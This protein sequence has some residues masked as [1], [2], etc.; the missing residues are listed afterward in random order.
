[1]S[2]PDGSQ[3]LRVVPDAG[4]FRLETKSGEA[5]GKVKVQGDRVKVEGA[6]GGARAKVKAKDY[7]FKVY[8]AGE[9]VVLKA[10]RRGSGFSFQRGDDTPLGRW[11]RGQGTLAG[12]KVEVV[13]RGGNR[14]VL[15]GGKDVATV[16]SA[17]PEEAAGLLA[18]TELSFEERLATLVFRL[19]LVKP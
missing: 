17:V 1:M 9:T 12:D 15:R 4:G 8:G 10:K 3:H 16:S 11:E 5:R 7:G 19:E 13:E 2:T 6:S 14:V 18:L